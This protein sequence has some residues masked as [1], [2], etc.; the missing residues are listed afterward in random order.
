MLMDGSPS[1]TRKEARFPAAASEQN[2]G[3]ATSELLFY[4]KTP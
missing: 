3:E 1:M 2:A 4:V